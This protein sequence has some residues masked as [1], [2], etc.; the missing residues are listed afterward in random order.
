MCLCMCVSV[1]VNCNCC[2]L[3]TDNLK[4]RNRPDD[5]RSGWEAGR[6]QD[7]SIETERTYMTLA[8]KASH[9]LDY[10]A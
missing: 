1:C 10:S 4:D 8:T 7:H 2:L 5:I 3:H 9:V 6:L